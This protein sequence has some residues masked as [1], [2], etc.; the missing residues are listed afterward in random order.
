M[1]DLPLLKHLSLYTHVLICEARLGGGE[2]R[3]G[4][5][6]PFAW[7]HLLLEGF[8]PSGFL[9]NTGRGVDFSALK[10]GYIVSRLWH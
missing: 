10:A 3:G 6:L 2:G 5:A 7:L 1:D 8:V 4:K 9:P